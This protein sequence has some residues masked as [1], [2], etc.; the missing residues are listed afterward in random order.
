MSN[1]RLLIETSRSLLIILAVSLTDEFRVDPSWTQEKSAASNAAANPH[2]RV[3]P[4][5]REERFPADEFDGKNCQGEEIRDIRP[6]KLHEIASSRCT[7]LGRRR[8]RAHARGKEPPRGGD[9]R[10]QTEANFHRPRF[11]APLEE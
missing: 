10:P 2:E 11:T 5:L 1:R 9:V 4:V 8:A 6:A 7:L 3:F